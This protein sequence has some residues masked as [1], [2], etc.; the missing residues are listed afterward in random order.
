MFVNS[1]ICHTAS[2][3]S[4]PLPVHYWRRYSDHFV[5]VCV[6]VCV[7][8]CLGVC[9]LCQHD[10]T[11]TPDRNDLKAGTVL[12]DTVR[13]PIDFG[14]KR[15][16]EHRFIIPMGRFSDPLGIFCSTSLADLPFLCRYRARVFTVFYVPCLGSES[17]CMMYSFIYRYVHTHGYEDAT[18]QH[19]QHHPRT[20]LLLKRPPPLYFHPRVRSHSLRTPPWPSPPPHCGLVFRSVTCQSISGEAVASPA[21][22]SPRRTCP[23]TPRYLCFNVTGFSKALITLKRRKSRC[24]FA[25]A[26]SARPLWYLFRLLLLLLLLN[27]YY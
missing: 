26:E 19:N 1:S 17:R 9:V 20:F 27:E 4:T 21:G 22:P 6:C 13:N 10:K 24:R 11:K 15:A 7:G 3:P 8:V 23:L 16:L 5:T 14:F 12:V 2:C 18:Y 25:S